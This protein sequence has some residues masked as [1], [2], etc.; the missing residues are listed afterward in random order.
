MA[1][2]IITA[3]K[4]SRKR[5]IIGL[6]ICLLV[7]LSLKYFVEPWV[8]HDLNFSDNPVSAFAVVEMRLAIIFAAIFP[9]CFANGIFT[10]RYALR[11]WR[12]RAH[13]P[14][15]TKLAF[16]TR[17][18]RGSSARAWSFAY[19]FFAFFSFLGVPAGVVYLRW[20]SSVLH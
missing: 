16:S 1:V 15:G 20:L 4:S 17:I 2:E 10:L 19:F 12:E 6:G 11:I 7:L 3:D 5:A 8:I 9:F 18:R 13:P 14:K